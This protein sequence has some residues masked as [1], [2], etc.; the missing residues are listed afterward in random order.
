MLQKVAVVA[1]HFRSNII[2]CWKCSK[3]TSPSLFCESCHSILDYRADSS[4]SHFEILNLKESLII[5]EDLVRTQF[6]E[7]SKQL[8]PDRFA[9]QPHP[10][11]VYALRW[12]TALNRAYQSLKNREERTRYLI[13]KYLGAPTQN[14]KSA[15]PLEMAESYFEALD[16]LSEGNKEPLIQF[17]LEVEKRLEESGKNWEKLA[18][19][20]DE[21]LNKIE[22][23]QLLRKHETE[24]KYFRSMLADIERKVTS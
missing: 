3:E 22:T 6:Y 19:Q 21:S 13:E 24:E 15:I 17:K 20:F 16:S 23:A 8:H 14:S 7:L 4:L 10:A 5:D 9:N 18:K 11:P 2:K 1:L 12:T